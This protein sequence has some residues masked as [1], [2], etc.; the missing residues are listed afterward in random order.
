MSKTLLPLW[1][2]ALASDLGIVIAAADREAT[3]QQLYT[4]RREAKDS[5]L[6]GLS[7]VLSPMDDSHIWIVKNAHG[8]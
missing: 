8:K 7:L 5:D 1:Y 6:D 4:A 3:R 2:E